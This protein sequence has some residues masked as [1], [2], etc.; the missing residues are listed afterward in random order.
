MDWLPEHF[1]R[2]DCDLSKLEKLDITISIDF[3]KVITPP[4]MNDTVEFVVVTSTNWKADRREE[5]KIEIKQTECI[6]WK[7]LKSG[8]PEFS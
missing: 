8:I 1:I 2:H 6:N 5:Q 3:D 4:R 7:F